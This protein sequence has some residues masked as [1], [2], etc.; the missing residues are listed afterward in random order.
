MFAE[1]HGGTLALQDLDCVFFFLSFFPFCLG[2]PRL[3]HNYILTGR[4]TARLLR[5]HLHSVNRSNIIQNHG[6]LL[7][8]ILTR[9]DKSH[10]IVDA[11]KDVVMQSSPSDG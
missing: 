3:P 2:T 8:H 11:C 10:V 6:Q 4:W 7:K 5:P 1:I 9:Q